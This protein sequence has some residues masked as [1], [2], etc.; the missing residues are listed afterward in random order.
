M[1]RSDFLILFFLATVLHLASIQ[2]AW[3]Q[4]ESFAKPLI[5]LSLLGYYLLNTPIRSIVFIVALAFCCL[6]DSLC[7]FSPAMKRF[8]DGLGIIPRRPCFFYAKLP[9]A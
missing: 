3:I 9:A 4:L 8:Y 2:G 5:V 1:K 6:G 7:Y